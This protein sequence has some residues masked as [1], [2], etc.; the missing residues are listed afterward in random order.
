MKRSQQ[1]E[2]VS[3]RSIKMEEYCTPGLIMISPGQQVPAYRILEMT[4]H[5]M[6]GTTPVNKQPE[7][8]LSRFH[9]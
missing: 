5:V 2:G 7:K 3:T 1:L 9:H 4:L 6:P 8:S